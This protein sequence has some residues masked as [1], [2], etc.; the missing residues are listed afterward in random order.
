MVPEPSHE[1][2]PEC[3]QATD[4]LMLLKNHASFAAVFLPL[5]RT[6]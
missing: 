5:V 3:S 6:A 4:Q 2:I 1:D